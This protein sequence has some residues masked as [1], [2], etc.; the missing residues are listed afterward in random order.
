MVKLIPARYTGEHDVVLSNYGGP[1]LD[2]DGKPLQS[3]VL[4]R[5]DTLMVQENEVK[6]FTVL[7]DPR[8]E[9]E[10][11]ILGVGRVVRDQDKDKDDTT[12]IAMGYQFHQPS[13]IWQDLSTQQ[14]SQ[15]SSKKT[16]KQE[17]VANV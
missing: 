11:Q 4:H 15:A 9:Q 3:L 7:L 8:H 12:L 17:G 16:A 14:Q 13:P 10:P 5:G 6:G 2:G 1:Y